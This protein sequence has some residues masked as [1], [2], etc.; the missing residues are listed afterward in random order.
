M[1]GRKDLMSLQTINTFDSMKI[2][3]KNLQTKRFQSS[4]LETSDIFGNNIKIIYLGA[5][6]KLHG[7]KVVNKPEF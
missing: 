1:P 3:T 4:N 2:T 7:S 5:S 6:P